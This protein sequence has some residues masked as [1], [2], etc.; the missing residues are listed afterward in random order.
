MKIILFRFQKE[1]VYFTE[2]FIDSG[3][4]AVNSKEK[5]EI[6]LNEEYI[7]GEKYK[8]LLNELSQIVEKHSP[9]L[10]MYQSPGLYMGSLKDREGFASATMLHLFCY[11][12]DIE[13]FEL[14]PTVVRNNL[15]IKL[16]DFKGLREQ[17]KVQ[18]L[19]DYK[20]LKSDKLFEGL[21]LLFLLRGTFES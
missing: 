4:L 14:T 21:V 20:I 2:C 1:K 9:N 15:A 18:V 16:K 13:L 6:S 12:N 8:R 7:P 10:I 5:E 19:K 11:Q 3:K 17:A